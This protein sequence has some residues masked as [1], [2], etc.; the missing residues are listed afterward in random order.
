MT[1][2]DFAIASDHAGF[3]LKNKI[4]SYFQKN[5]VQILD[6]GTDNSDSVDYPDYA[7]KLIDEI[8]EETVSVGILICGTGIGMSIAANRNSEIRA[9]LCLNEFMAERARLHNDA[10]VLVLGSEITDEKSAVKIIQKFLKTIFE[11]GRH[12]NRLQKIL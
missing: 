10:N 8:I 12:V 2:F 5:N 4:I 11:G 1:D 3:E 7:K 9:A 6:L